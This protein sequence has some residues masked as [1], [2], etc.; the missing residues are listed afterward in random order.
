[1]L[2]RP[3]L[4]ISHPHSHPLVSSPLGTLARENLSHGE[5]AAT[6]QRATGAHR[7]EPW[8]P[9]DAQAEDLHE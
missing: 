4:N 5:G 3:P 8:E 1:M 2:P 7:P 6:E 9:P